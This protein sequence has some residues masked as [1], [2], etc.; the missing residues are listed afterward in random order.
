MDGLPGLM[1]VT[2]SCTCCDGGGRTALKWD[3][4]RYPSHPT[5]NGPEMSTL[6]AVMCE[7]FF[8]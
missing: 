4:L 5:S 7:C 3:G 6:F 2:E 8:C 1:G